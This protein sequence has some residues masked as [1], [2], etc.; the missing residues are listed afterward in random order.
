M[1]NSYVDL[2]DSEYLIMF[3]LNNGI[4]SNKASGFKK[5]FGNEKLKLSSKD[6]YHT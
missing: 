1:T 3:T 4:K 2:K 5:L 6:N